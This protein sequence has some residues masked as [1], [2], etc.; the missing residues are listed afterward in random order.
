MPER[1]FRT[2]PYHGGWID[3]KIFQVKD[4]WCLLSYYTVCPE[5]PDGSGRILMGRLLLGILPSVSTS[6]IAAAAIVSIA[7]ITAGA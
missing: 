5:A 1:S 6:V 4:H 7:V 3:M 2:E